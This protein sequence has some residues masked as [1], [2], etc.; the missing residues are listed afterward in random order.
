MRPGAE[1]Y[2]EPGQR[3]LRLERIFLLMGRYLQEASPQLAH[4]AVVVKTIIFGVGAGLVGRKAN[5]KNRPSLGVLQFWVKTVKR[6]PILV[7]IG[8]FTTHVRTYFT[9]GWDGYW[10][11][12]LAIDPFRPC[13]PQPK[14]IRVDGPV[15]MGPSPP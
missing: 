4:A 13:E 15:S 6:D 7:G 3:K 9:G 8:E 5:G 10:G 2:V 12:N 1:L 11:Y 14:P